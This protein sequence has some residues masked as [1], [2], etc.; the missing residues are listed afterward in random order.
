MSQANASGDEESGGQPA[1]RLRELLRRQFGEVPAESP[2]E[3]GSEREEPPALPD[4]SA[5]G[6][7]EA[8]DN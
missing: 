6:G 8:A 5:S 3:H 7:E 4:E 2:S 1:R